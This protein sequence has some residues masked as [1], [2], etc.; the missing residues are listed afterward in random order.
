MGKVFAAVQR[1]TDFYRV[2]QITCFWKML[3][4]KLV[5]F[6]QISFF[7]LKVQS[8]R[9]IIENN[10]IQK[11]ASAGHTVPTRSIQFLST[12]SIVMFLSYQKHFK[13]V[14]VHCKQNNNKVVFRFRSVFHCSHYFMFHYNTLFYV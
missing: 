12:L 3:E 9:L 7:Y 6:S 2:R 10:F 13:Y 11:A 1:E 8:S 5:I 4:N 14:F